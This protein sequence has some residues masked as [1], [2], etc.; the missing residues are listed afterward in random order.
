MR[1]EPLDRSGR[2]RSMF[3][4]G[5]ESSASVGTESF[6]PDPSRA[7]LLQ[8]GQLGMGDN[9]SYNQPTEV[10]GLKGKTVASAACG[11]NHTVDLRLSLSPCHAPRLLPPALPDL[12][13]EKPCRSL[14][15]STLTRSD[16]RFHG[17]CRL[18]QC[19]V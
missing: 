6:D 8:M 5:A 14:P 16:A 1:R 17:H 11:K 3:C 19:H 12:P 7:G 4:M 2:Y 13:L 18:T 9:L 15:W 10:K